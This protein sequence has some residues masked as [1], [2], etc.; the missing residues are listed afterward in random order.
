[1]SA[2]FAEQVAQSLLAQAL[3]VGTRLYTQGPEPG[4]RDSS[5]P[6]VFLDGQCFEKG[7]SLLWSDDR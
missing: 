6:E 1:M 2:V 7:R 5:Y 4:R 3:E